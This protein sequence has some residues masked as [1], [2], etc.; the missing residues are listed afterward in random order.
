[1]TVIAQ[2]DHLTAGAWAACDI[3][4][5]PVYPGVILDCQFLRS[6]FARIPLYQSELPSKTPSSFTS[7]SVLT[8]V[9]LYIKVKLFRLSLLISGSVVCNEVLI[10]GKQG[11]L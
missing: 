5:F 6:D 11:L 2:D 10:F 8:L 3:Y 4:C 9:Q 7:Q 1:M